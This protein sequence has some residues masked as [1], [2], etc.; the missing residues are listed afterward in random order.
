MADDK[1]SI[2]STDNKIYT[3]DFD[4]KDKKKFLN[5]MFT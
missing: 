1:I 2:Q 4:G 3:K 5:D